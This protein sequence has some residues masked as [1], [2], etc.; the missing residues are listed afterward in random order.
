[1]AITVCVNPLLDGQGEKLVTSYDQYRSTGIETQEEKNP[2]E[3]GVMTI[4]SLVIH[5]VPDGF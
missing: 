5:G 4:K 1:M 2:C 3:N